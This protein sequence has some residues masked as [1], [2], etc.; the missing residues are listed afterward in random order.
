[1]Y[2]LLGIFNGFMLTTV[3]G[4]N[5]TTPTFWYTTLMIGLVIFMENKD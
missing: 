5:V 4:H 2:L 3:L 1:M